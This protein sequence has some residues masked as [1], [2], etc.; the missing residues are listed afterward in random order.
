MLL[1]REPQIQWRTILYLGTGAFPLS[2][3]DSSVLGPNMALNIE[4][5]LDKIPERK[6]DT[7][8][9]QVSSLYLKVFNIQYDLYP[10]CLFSPL[11]LP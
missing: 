11:F 8:R 1:Q 9:K 3:C 10:T 7:E 4:Y 2:G 6:R 5:V